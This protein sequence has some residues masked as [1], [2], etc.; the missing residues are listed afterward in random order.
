[1]RMK[2]FGT[3]VAATK[4]LNSMIELFIDYVDL[5]L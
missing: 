4:S 5:F 2:N 3:T 1:M